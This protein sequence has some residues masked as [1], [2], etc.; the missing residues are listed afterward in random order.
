MFDYI[1]AGVPVLSSG[2]I[3]IKKII[4]EYAIGDCITSHE[5]KHIAEKMNAILLDENK[6]QLWKKNTKIASEKLNWE[7]E[8]K[9]LIEVYSRF[10]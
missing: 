4:D 5:P 6:L 3:E 2:L 10:L 1:H 8:E 9:Q 7:N